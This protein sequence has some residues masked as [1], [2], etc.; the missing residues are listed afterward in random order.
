MVKE[1]GFVF[2][3]I[4]AG[5]IRRYWS[6]RNFVDPFLTMAG[7]WQALSILRRFKPD[8]VFGKGSY[9]TPP[10]LWAARLLKVPVV[11]HE[12]DAV[13]GL[14]NRLGARRAAK[15]AVSF[16]DTSGLP[17]DKLVYTGVPLRDGVIKG[18]A[19]RAVQRFRLDK[20]LPTVLV[21]GGSQGAQAISEALTAALPRLL[22][23]AQIVHQTGERLAA[24]VAK[25][26]QELPRELR[27]RYHPHGFFGE[28]L[29]DLYAAVDLVV[30]RSGS[31]VAEIAATGLPS[32]LIPLP[33]AAGDHQRANAEV[34]A[35]AGA[36]IVLEQNELTS[37]SLTLVVKKLLHD[38]SRRVAMGRCARQLAQIDAADRVAELVW[39]VATKN[40]EKNAKD[41]AKKD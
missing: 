31:A 5:K 7:A 34:F 8:V 6:W 9:V 24:T 25:V 40:V 32:I 35:K 30:T 23:E 4:S 22:L 21:L 26:K 18:K 1:A 12:S 20:R 10:V 16:P 33:S 3:A 27:G 28:E 2:A 17:E 38:A 15:V 13:A 29:F 14:A 41:D 19:A 39:E 11:L 37:D 36:A